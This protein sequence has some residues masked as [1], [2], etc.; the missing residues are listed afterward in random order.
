MLFALGN[1]CRRVDLVI[2]IFC[3]LHI[4][5]SRIADPARI[6]LASVAAS[7]GAAVARMH[8]GSI[9]HGDLTT[10]NMMLRPLVAASNAALPDSSAASADSSSLSSDSTAS[11]ASSGA[12]VGVS[13]MSV[14]AAAASSSNPAAA[15]H[16]VVVIDFGLRYD[17]QIRVEF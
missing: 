16:S 6:L 5:F 2:V 4:I 7:I 8:D 15:S 13:D 14:D 10:S 9:I 3:L 11:A 1:P 12:S 17:G